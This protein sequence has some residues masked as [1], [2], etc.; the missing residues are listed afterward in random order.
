MESNF[1]SLWGASFLGRREPWESG[2]LL[3]LKGARVQEILGHR[4]TLGLLL[5]L[6]I[7]TYH[8][9]SP[10]KDNIGLIKWVGKC[11]MHSIF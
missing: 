5:W 6:L 4:E 7:L 8:F 1:V 10:N 11:S 3:C 2:L 9:L